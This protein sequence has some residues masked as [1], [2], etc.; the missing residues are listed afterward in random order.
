MRPW[1]AS[2]MAI[3]ANIV[4]NANSLNVIA[5]MF[6]SY[7]GWCSMSIG[8]KQIVNNSRQTDKTNNC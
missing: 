6:D 5:N 2:A 4:P 7:H 8:E 3:I 1:T